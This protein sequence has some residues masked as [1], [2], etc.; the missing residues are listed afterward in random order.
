MQADADW[1]GPSATLPFSEVSPGPDGAG[2]TLFV[3]INLLYYYYHYHYF[4]IG[5]YWAAIAA[6]YLIM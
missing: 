2:G 3:F 1:I 6:L 5:C 4:E